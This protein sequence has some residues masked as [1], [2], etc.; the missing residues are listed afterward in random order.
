MAP[1]KLEANE[2]TSMSA[3]GHDA[4]STSGR[5]DMTMLRGYPERLGSARG[6]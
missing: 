1:T 4:V 3:M 2:A 5:S 6:D